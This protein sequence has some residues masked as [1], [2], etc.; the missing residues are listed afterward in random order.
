MILTDFLYFHYYGYI[1]LYNLDEPNIK[2]W[3]SSSGLIFDWNKGDT[4]N[5]LEFD[6]VDH[7]LYH[8][9]EHDNSQFYKTK[10]SYFEPKDQ[11]N[12][13]RRIALMLDEIWTNLKKN[14]LSKYQTMPA[15]IPLEKNVIEMASQQ[16]KWGIRYIFKIF[17]GNPILKQIFELNLLNNQLDKISREKIIGTTIRFPQNTKENANAIQLILDNINLGA[18]QAEIISIYPIVE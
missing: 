3:K 7:F 5:L 18:G 8:T 14:Q 6:R 2:K 13:K 11:I 12:I 1:P 9:Q 10:H 15:K 16:V 17:Q 4:D